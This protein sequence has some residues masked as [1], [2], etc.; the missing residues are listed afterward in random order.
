MRCASCGHQWYQ[1]APIDFPQILQPDAPP[2]APAEDSRSR[3]P[4]ANLPGFPRR[5]RSAGAAVAWAVLALAAIILALAAWVGRDAIM[6]AWPPSE[7]L[8]ATIGGVTEL[9]GAGLEFRNVTSVRRLEADREVV[10]IEGDVVNVST[11]DRQVPKLRVALTADGHEVTEWTFEATQ[12][13]LL[14]GESARFVTRTN[15]PVEDATGL[16]LDFVGRN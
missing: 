2:Q 5:Q 9:P 12:S 16:S 15:E 1:R 7:R 6:A 8:Y 10:V 14:P 11:R 4:G 3:A 13:Q